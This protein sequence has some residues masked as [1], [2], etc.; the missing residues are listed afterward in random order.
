MSDTDGIILGISLSIGITSVV[1]LLSYVSYKI[2]VKFH[3]RHGS[4][5]SNEST[6][7]PSPVVEEVVRPQRSQYSDITVRFFE[8]FGING[9]QPDPAVHRQIETI[10]VRSTD[11]LPEYHE[12]ADSN[13]PSYHEAISVYK[14]EN[15]RY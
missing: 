13:P 6:E 1:F 8:E 5:T 10:R 15:E 7:P 4:D 12:V 9:Y 14:V 2:G 11:V 3:D